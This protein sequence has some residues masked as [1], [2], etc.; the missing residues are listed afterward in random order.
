LRRPNSRSN[1]RTLEIDQPFSLAQLAPLALL[2]LR[3]QGTC[4]FQIPEY[5]FDLFYPGHYRRKIKAVRLTIPCIP[6]PCTYVS[7]TLTLTS[8][9]ISREP[10]PPGP[11]GLTD[12]PPRRSVSIA[13]STAQADSGVFEMSFRDER[14]MPFEGAG[15]ISSWRLSLPGSFRQ[16]D[17]S[18]MLSA[19]RTRLAEL[20]A[21]LRAIH[22]GPTL[23]ATFSPFDR[24]GR[25]VR[26]RDAGRITCSQMLNSR[27]AAR[28]VR[29]RARLGW[30]GCAQVP[31]ARK[32]SR[33]RSSDGS[34][35][36][37]STTAASMRCAMASACMEPQA[38]SSAPRRLVPKKPSGVRLSVTPSV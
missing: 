24:T 15:A 2:A 38:C 13:T 27:G 1:H 37:A 25:Y 20:A 14:Y 32:T 11:A 18:T 7:A 23:S 17:Y 33:A 36:G 26:T 31:T 19:V 28:D 8:S 22:A 9:Q 16:F 5:A 3:E 10:A 6:G 30:P 12:V 29:R 4:E 34:C 21:A 35:A